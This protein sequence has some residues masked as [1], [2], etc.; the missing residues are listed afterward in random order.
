MTVEILTVDDEEDIRTTL[1]MILG[2]KGWQ[3]HEAASIPE[4]MQQIEMHSDIGVVL[5]DIRLGHQSGLDGIVRMN[6]ETGRDLEYIV[7]SGDGGMDEAVTALRLGAADFLRKPFRVDQV[8]ASVERCAER[9]S[10]RREQT[11]FRQRVMAEIRSRDQRI[12]E[13]AKDVDIAQIETLKTLATAAE[14]RDNETGAHIKR[15][16]AYARVFG[17]ALGW[18]PSLVDRIGQAAQL[19][20]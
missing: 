6:N 13:L 8:T 17:K 10:Q 7:I 15:I 9:Y 1:S 19:E 11:H 2:R 18:D 4:A 16:G 12:H 14:Q 3:C 5:V 20:G